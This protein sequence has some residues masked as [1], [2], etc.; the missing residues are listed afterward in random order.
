LDI[1]ARR[2]CSLHY[3][4]HRANKFEIVSGYIIVA[5]FMGPI[6][7]L[8]HLRAGDSFIVESLVPHMFLS[9]EDSCML[10]EYFPD[11][12][13]TIDVNDIVRIVEGG[14]ISPDT[15]V[16]DVPYALLQDL[17]HQVISD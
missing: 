17:S 16:T 6:I 2:Y 9:V 15:D 1:I 13:G 4:C 10:E 12:G 8:A 11:R 3:H 14:V 7:N 5:K